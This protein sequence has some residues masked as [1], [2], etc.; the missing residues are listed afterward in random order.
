MTN[1]IKN[2]V[3][4]LDITFSKDN[5]VNFRDYFE[6]VREGDDLKLRSKKVYEH[7][8]DIAPFD[9]LKY[10]YVIY[11]VNAD[12]GATTENENGEEV[13]ADMYMVYLVPTVECMSDDKVMELARVFGLEDMPIDELRAEFDETDFAEEG[14]GVFL[15]SELDEAKTW[16]DMEKNGWSLPW[17]EDIINGFATAINTLDSMVGWV[18]DKPQNGFGKTGWDYIEACMS[19][20]SFVL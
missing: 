14:Y 4:S 8:D 11:G 20:K 6:V 13:P 1:E 15:G 2:P 10:R 17:N 18:L 19:D 16:E 7:G 12:A 9:K 5:I 3:T